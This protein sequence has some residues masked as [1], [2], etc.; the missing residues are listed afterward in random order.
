MTLPLRY[1]L[2][3]PGMPFNGHTI[4]TASLGG[5]E[6]AG[7][8]LA[9][10]LARHGHEVVVWCNTPQACDVDGV[11]Y[12][13]LGPQNEQFPFG[14]AFTE[15]VRNIP[16]D[17]TIC[18]R[19]PGI[20]NLPMCSQVRLWW[21]HDLAQG[22]TREAA[23]AGLWNC[24]GVLAV[25]EWHKRQVRE[26][27]GLPERFVH[28]I[29]NGVDLGLFQPAAAEDKIA[30][31]RMVY[32]SRPERGLRYLV[33]PG[34]IMAQ[35]AQ[36]QPGI[37][38]LVCT[39]DHAVPR[40][41]ALYGQ[42]R[43]WA[44]A[45]PNVLLLEPKTKAGMARLMGGAWLHAYPAVP[46]REFEE[47]SCMAVM[48]AQ[49]AGTPC[50]VPRYGALSETLDGGGA[51]F[52]T[53]PGEIH[54]D[55]LY[56]QAFVNEI[57]DLAE[58][59]GRWRELHA[60]ALAKAP[61]YDVEKPAAAVSAL[62]SVT[63]HEAAQQPARLASHLLH[64][65][66]ALAFRQI[67]GD[68]A[69]LTPCAPLHHVERG[70]VEGGG[71]D[72]RL[73]AHWAKFEDTLAKLADPAA[74]AAF[75]EKLQADELAS[76][77]THRFGDP[78]ILDMERARA[79][80]PFL[81]ALPPGARVLDYGCC[82]GQFTHAFARRFPHLEFVGVDL[83]AANIAKG[84]ALL[85]GDPQPNATL[86]E[87]GGT[88]PSPALP[89]PE[90]REGAQQRG[91]QC[92]PPLGGG[93]APLP[94]QPSLPQGE[95]G[96]PAMRFTPPR[97]LRQLRGGAGGE[98]LFD[99]VLAMEVLEHAPDPAGL[100][101]RLE[102]LCIPDGRVVATFPNGAVEAAR[103][104]VTP[105]REHVHHFTHHDLAAMWSRKPG[106]GYAHFNWGELSTEGAPLGGTMVTW[107]RGGDP[108][109]APAF[110]TR[111]LHYVPRE[112]VSACLIVK[113][114]ETAVD[115]CLKSIVP[116]VDE[117]I[118]GI[119]MTGAP[120]PP[121]PSLPLG[122]GGRPATPFTPPRL[123]RQLRGGAGGEV[124]AWDY[125]VQHG[126][127]RVFAL[128]H[129]P[130]KDGFDAARNETIARA[131]G[132]WILWIDADEVL[133]HGERM[134]KYLRRNHVD[135]YCIAQQHLAVDPK[136]LLRTDLPTRLFRR[137]SGYRFYG[138][139]HEH[140]CPAADKPPEFAMLIP[141]Q[142][143]CIGHM[144]YA[145]NE[146][147]MRRFQ[148]NW[149]LM[150]RDRIEHPGRQL[151]K[152]LWVRDLSHQSSWALGRGDRGA[153][154]RFAEETLREWRLLLQTN[155]ARLVAEAV[156]YANQAAELLAGP[157]ALHVQ[158]ALA[159]FQAGV[160]QPPNAPPPLVRLCFVSPEDAEAFLAV[161]TKATF[162]TYKARYF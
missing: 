90:E 43:A 8:Y 6:S 26:V 57:C 19:A 38:L 9:T 47:V 35:L 114:D 12:V 150:Q 92:T 28:A 61:E 112:R 49:A 33:Q 162:E 71:E 45:L 137:D 18:Q 115:R 135:A 78:G 121:Q 20:F 79:V 136:G 147:R 103:F 72:S 145:T 58:K 127:D 75:Y 23:L 41:A 60:R 99:L 130:L 102:A 70:D 76:G 83:S 5:S 105:W 52:V 30:G 158:T 123:L 73:R 63:Q 87:I 98:V 146:I 74:A 82:V 142:D 106:Y 53:E 154:A 21:T 151:G 118:V 88:S 13:P 108:V 86:H 59:P 128:E 153:A 11:S 64:M 56:V 81:R 69:V 96:R 133:F 116:Y 111:A 141:E 126:A 46:P 37:T 67:F 24:H 48:E 138:R 109:G 155:D 80:E 132:E 143:L 139:V 42:L 84:R 22:R 131:G 85:A 54:S 89:L 51:A 3:V 40:M 110:A 31:K 1:F 120:L 140:P 107:K 68:A 15:G 149:P 91:K 65:S 100:A 62:V 94:P 152:M 4:R 156:P 10:R 16:H 29:P 124:P 119:D 7:Y 148:R 101:R 34:G 134:A 97:L 39:Y 2:Y 117:L 27:H 144:G 122:E 50:V 44:A 17:V 36:R 77:N 66:D 104:A 55:E 157:G 32:S 159:A 161:F 93:R 25:S 113:W 129:P 125:A 14:Q 95:G 160:G